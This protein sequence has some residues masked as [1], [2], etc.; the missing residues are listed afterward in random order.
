M[1]IDS[2]CYCVKSKNTKVLVFALIICYNM[3]YVFSGD[4]SR[5]QI[6]MF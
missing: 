5:F 1:P 4:I 3:Q 6:S 2:G